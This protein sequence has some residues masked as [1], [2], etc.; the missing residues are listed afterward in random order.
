MENQCVPHGSPQL[1]SPNRSTRTTCTMHL[2]NI[3]C[4]IH[5]EASNLCLELILYL[6]LGN[7]FA[8]LTR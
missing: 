2:E 6:L 4:D 8:R 3:L 5:A 1:T 7:S